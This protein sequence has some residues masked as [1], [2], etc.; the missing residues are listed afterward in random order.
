MMTRSARTVRVGTLLAGCLSVMVVVGATTTSWAPRAEAAGSRHFVTS[1]SIAPF[2]KALVRSSEDSGISS[3]ERH[4]DR[5]EDGRTLRP[6]TTTEVPCLFDGRSNQTP[7]P[8]V[9]PGSSISISC[10]GFQPDDSVAA[11]E[12]S[13]LALTASNSTP[14]FDLNLQFYTANS[15]GDLTGNFVVPNPFYAQNSDAVCPPT[16]AQVASGYL[17]CFIF[18]VDY[19]GDYGSIVALNYAQP[20][21]WMVGTDGG[22]FAFGNAGYY[23]SLPQHHVVVD[24]IKAVV[25]TSDGKGYWM[26]GADGGVFAFGDAPYLGSL[27]GVHVHV[28][29]IVA[30]VPTSDGKGYWMVG[31]DGGVFAFGDAPYLGSLPGL[32]VR[33][34]DIVAVV[35][36][37]EGN[38]YLMVGGD[39][40]VFAFGDAGYHGSLPGIHVHVDDVVGV[41]PTN[42]GAGYWMV[43]A[44]GGVFAFGDAG[45]LGSLPG[46]HVHVDDVV[47]VV[48]TNNGAGYWMVGKDG[49]VFAFG[50]APFLGSLPG[51]HVRVDDIVAVVRA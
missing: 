19:S 27:P 2:A 22:V 3:L 51:L 15:A 42:N 33:V 6:L 20:G 31:A 45:Y 9:E 25:P 49:G 50:D 11:V 29:D 1:S 12:G 18:L 43:G 34:D 41:V 21:Y 28:D 23:G 38:G 13:P 10:T 37:P 8:N 39:G 24:D 47:G 16:P 17:R 4:A 35:P 48:P 5:I 46:I 7:V 30:V 14:D 36:S 32:H 26:V 44:D 40:G